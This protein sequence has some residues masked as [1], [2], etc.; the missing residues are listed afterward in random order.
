VYNRGRLTAGADHYHVSATRK[1]LSVHLLYDAGA[2]TYLQASQRS[3]TREI[4]MGSL[5][6]CNGKILRVFRVNTV[7]VGFQVTSVA[8]KTEHIPE[9]LSI[10]ELIPYQMNG[11]S[12]I[13]SLTDL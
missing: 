13:L 11:V 9:F 5:A 4:T 12:G 2:E 8:L 3:D 7:S 6:H 1:T 10:E